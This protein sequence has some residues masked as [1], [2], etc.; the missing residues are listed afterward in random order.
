[1]EGKEMVLLFLMEVIVD[2]ISLFQYH[3]KTTQV[4]KLLWILNYLWYCFV[5][6]FF[7][8]SPKFLQ[9]VVF[10]L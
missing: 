5:L 6:V 3:G 4:Q 10:F 1:V 8:A 9:D 2:Q 7:N